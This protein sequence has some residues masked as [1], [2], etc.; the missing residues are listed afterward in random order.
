MDL[1][2]VDLCKARGE[3]LVYSHVLGKPSGEVRVINLEEST[4]KPMKNNN[5]P[6]KRTTVKS[7]LGNTYINEIEVVPEI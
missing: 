4:C 3:S 6:M 1:A 7:I 5:C 2:V